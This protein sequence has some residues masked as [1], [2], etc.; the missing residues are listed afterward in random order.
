MWLLPWEKLPPLILGPLL[1]LVGVLVLFADSKP[2]EQLESLLWG[3]GAVVGGVVVTAYG[4]IKE[5]R[6]QRQ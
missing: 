4:V 6:K 2:A 3:I 5:C 1:I